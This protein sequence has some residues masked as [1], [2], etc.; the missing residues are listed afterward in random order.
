MGASTDLNQKIHRDLYVLHRPFIENAKVWREKLRTVFC[1]RLAY[2]KQRFI[3]DSLPPF[4]FRNMNESKKINVY[5]HI[6]QQINNLMYM[7]KSS[8]HALL[9]LWMVVAIIFTHLDFQPWFS[10]LPG[11]VLPLKSWFLILEL[12]I[13]V[14][15]TS[16][17]VKL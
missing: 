6:P 8:A 12:V 7:P 11:S 9:I 3:F 14:W 15:G 4:F 5:S 1:K 2:L 17:L 13:R 16:F 10:P